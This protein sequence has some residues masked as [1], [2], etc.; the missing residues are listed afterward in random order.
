MYC[1]DCFGYNLGARGEHV[2]IQLLWA[3]ARLLPTSVNLFYRANE[4]HF[5]FLLLVL[6]QTYTATAMSEVVQFSL[7]GMFGDN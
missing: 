5:L 7:R 6:S 1:F 4:F 2:A 3:I